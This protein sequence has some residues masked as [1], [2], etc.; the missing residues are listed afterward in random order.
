MNVE[1]V[2]S[3]I[4]FNMETQNKGELLVKLKYDNSAMGIKTAYINP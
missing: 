1:K 3:L 4:E 2:E